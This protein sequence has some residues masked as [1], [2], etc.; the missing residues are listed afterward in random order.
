MPVSAEDLYAEIWGKDEP[1]LTAALNESL[2]PRSS[3]ALEELFDRYSG[4]AE[5]LCPPATPLSAACIDF[6]AVEGVR[7][8]YGRVRVMAG[9]PGKER[10][11]ALRRRP[12]CIG[13][14][15][16]FRLRQR[17][18][19]DTVGRVVPDSVEVLMLFAPRRRLLGGHWRTS[20]FCWSLVILL[21][22]DV[23]ALCPA[24]AP[25]SCDSALTFASAR[26]S[27]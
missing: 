16:V 26:A 7:R 24:C 1:A 27:R 15:H 3:A 21:W 6:V 20:Y 23:T 8:R 25:G 17:K 13:R 19:A 2:N 22:R 11:C 18:P 14:R 12:L 10:G 4:A 9:G 5:D